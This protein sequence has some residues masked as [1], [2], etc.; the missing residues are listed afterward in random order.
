MSKLQE[1][2]RELCPDGVEYKKLGEIVIIKNG[3]DYKHLGKGNIPVYGSGGIM[4]YVDTYAYN[5]PTVLIP[6]KGSLGNLFYVDKPFWNVDTVFYTEI[7]E[8]QM[9]A[10]YL[11]YTLAKE[12]LE[13][14]NNAGGVPSLTQTILNKVIIPVPPL[15]VQNEIVRILDDFTNLAAELQAELQAR[16]EQYE[17]YRN[18]L[19]SFNNISGGGY[20]GVTWMKMSEVYN[21]KAGKCISASEIY[22]CKTIESLYPCYGGNGMRGYVSKFNQC[23]ENI[24]I[25]RQGALCG[26]VCYAK[27]KYYA[28]E[29]AVVV[30][31]KGLCIPRYTFHLL[32]KMNLNQYKTAG[33][34]PGLSVTRL[35]T[36]LVPVP[37]IAE[38]ERIVAI[39]DKFE[40]LTSDLS[41]GLPAEITAV[42]EQYEYYRDKLLSFPRNKISA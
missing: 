27:G 7:D 41:Q 3:R 20:T 39:L 18:K 16:Q 26:N 25:G 31:E 17:Y 38:Q 11:Y 15:D 8:N 21:M 9:I 35:E 29:H 22:S 36:V 12:H 42:Q 32:T 23:G 4:T 10:K 33:A 6:R 37:S 28:T 1:L 19:L 30:S 34:Q 24:L 2:I 40:S 13:N 5:K 14:L